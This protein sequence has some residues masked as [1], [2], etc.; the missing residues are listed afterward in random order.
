MRNGHMVESDIFGRN[1]FIRNN[2][3]MYAGPYMGRRDDTGSGFD[4]SPNL[5]LHTYPAQIP[6]NESYGAI[7]GQRG[8]EWGFGGWRYGV[9][10]F[11]DWTPD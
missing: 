6:S 9:T 5:Y 7:A 3:I 8:S 4:A 1:A 2:L 10:E 11:V